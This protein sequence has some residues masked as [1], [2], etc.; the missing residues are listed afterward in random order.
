MLRKAR[1]VLIELAEPMKITESDQ[2]K[3]NTHHKR[4]DSSS[5]RRVAYRK[6]ITRSRDR[7]GG[8]MAQ[9]L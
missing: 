5:R 6:A 3:K 2:I 8:A 4:D 9:A 7:E 1:P